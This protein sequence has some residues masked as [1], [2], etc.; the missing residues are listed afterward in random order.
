MCA[1]CGLETRGSSLHENEIDC[2]D[3]QGVC[4]MKLAAFVLNAD[5]EPAMN[6]DAWDRE[7]PSCWILNRLTHNSQ[8]IA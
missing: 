4:S 1:A 3:F 8:Q 7:S 2:N 6:N 5:C